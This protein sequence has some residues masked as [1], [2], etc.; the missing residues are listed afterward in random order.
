MNLSYSLQKI[1]DIL[2]F[3]NIYKYYILVKN[4]FLYNNN[5]NKCLKKN[6]IAMKLYAKSGKC[7]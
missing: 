4:R 5:N 7:H 1:R 2:S 6:Y 3:P